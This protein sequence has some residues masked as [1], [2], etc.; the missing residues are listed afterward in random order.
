MKKLAGMG[1][2]LTDTVT[3][4]PHHTVLLPILEKRLRERSSLGLIVIT[5]GGLDSVEEACGSKVFNSLLRDVANCLESMQGVA[6]RQDDLLALSELGGTSF[7]IFLSDR[8]KDRAKHPLERDDVEAVTERV[9]EHLFRELMVV[10]HRHCKG[11]PDLAVGHSFVVYNP[12]IRKR[13]LIIRLIE[14]ARE[15]ARLQ[16]P[17]LKKRYKEILQRVIVNRE[18]RTL[19]QPI[20]D[21]ES[22]KLIGIEALTRG[23]AGT[24]LESPLSLFSIAEECGLIFELDRLCRHQALCESNQLPKDFTVFVNTLP[25][26]VQDPQFRGQRLKKFLETMNRD[27]SRIVFEISERSAIENYAT[28]KESMF[29]YLDQGINFAIDDTGTGYSSLEAIIQ[30]HPKFLKFDM[31]MVQG[32][33]ADP[34]KQEMLKMMTGLAKKIGSKVIAEGIEDPKDLRMLKTLGID[35]G[36]GFY[37]SRPVSAR[38]I[39]K[40]SSSFVASSNRAA[41]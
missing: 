21:L 34:L 1:Q 39:R 36:Q 12:L 26:S 23:P 8:Q 25:T 15:M 9:R 5:V 3:K 11:L 4:L 37:F 31:S 6:I 29:D 32:I 35:L 30:L 19:F 10:L 41:G 7:M 24:V 40:M 38:E 17:I 18:L 16:Q 2:V 28:F 14:E 20:L 27:A 33:F 22:E 13:R